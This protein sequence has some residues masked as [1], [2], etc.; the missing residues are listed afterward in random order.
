MIYG[1]VQDRFTRH[2]RLEGRG[3]SGNNAGGDDLQALLPSCN[4]NGRSNRS[5]ALGN[6]NHNLASSRCSLS[7]DQQSVTPTSDLDAGVFAAGETS[8]S[9]SPVPPERP[10]AQGQR[11]PLDLPPK[12]VENDIET[13]DLLKT[14]SVDQRRPSLDDIKKNP[15]CRWRPRG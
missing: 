2:D 3:G 7:S 14:N 5:Q 13:K 6:I 9:D 10:R 1:W 15:G 12:P 8:D 11:P 4:R